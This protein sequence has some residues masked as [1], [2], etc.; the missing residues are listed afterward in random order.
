M[1]M[2]RRTISRIVHDDLHLSGYKVRP[3]EAL[4]QKQMEARVKKAKKL[5]L[6][7]GKRNLGKVIFTDEK[8]F[9]LDESGKHPQ[10]KIHIRRGSRKTNM[11]Q[12][13]RFIHPHSPG[14]MVWGGVSKKGRSPLIFVEPGVKINARYYQDS[15]LTPFHAWCNFT[16]GGTDDIKLQQDWAPAHRA[17]STKEWLR[18]RN[19]HFWDEDVY[20]AASPDLN[21][22]DFAIWGWMLDRLRNQHIDSLEHLKRKILEIWDNLEQNSI[23]KSIDQLPNRLELLLHANGSR[24][25]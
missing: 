24:F 21:P 15:I 11:A 17:K 10:V 12:H 9:T 7:V 20:P 4:S 1:Q 13:G 16:F 19:V 8:I 23:D 2:S 3:Y 22:M 18:T 25:E 5:K 14:I 6:L